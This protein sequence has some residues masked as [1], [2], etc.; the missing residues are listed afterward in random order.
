MAPALQAP[1]LDKAAQ[2][3]S[4]EADGSNPVQLTNSAALKSTP[5]WSPDGKTLLIGV[6]EKEKYAVVAIS[7]AD[8]SARYVLTSDHGIGQMAWMG[9]G[10][11]FVYIAYEPAV[12]GGQIYYAS[13]P[14]GKSKRLTN[15]LTNYALPVLSITP[16]ASAMAVVQFQNSFGIYTASTEKPDEGKQVTETGFVGEHIRWLPNGKLLFNRDHGKMMVSEADGTG[17][18][19][20]GDKFIS[21]ESCGKYLVFARQS[22]DTDSRAYRADLDGKNVTPVGAD[23]PQ[24]FA[25]CPASG[26]NIYCV[27]LF[28]QVVRVPAEG[29]PAQPMPG[30]ATESTLVGKVSP[31]EKMF[32]TIETGYREG[33]AAQKPNQLRIV[34]IAGGSIGEFAIPSGADPSGYFSQFVDRTWTSDSKAVAYLDTRNGITNIWSQPVAGGPPMQLTHFTSDRI[35]SFDFSPDGKQIVYS[36]GHSSSDAVRIT[37]LK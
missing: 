17:A 10:R 22:G 33:V 31:D 3:F 12:G 4:A 25:S 27:R 7:V 14:E 9:S 37:N 36:R 1:A 34:S 20:I 19:Q 26:Q 16:D 30:I 15:D 6:R 32:Y 24:H 13:Y 28:K 8:G 35:T 5:T 18:Q 23:P 11:G 2:L 29:G 21:Y